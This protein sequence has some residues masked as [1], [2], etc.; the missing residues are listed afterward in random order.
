MGITLR[1][2]SSGPERSA[3]TTVV[4]GCITLFLVPFAGMG[5]LAAGSGLQRGMQ[6]NWREGLLLMLF[7][8]VFT[9]FAA[10]F[11]ALMVVGRNQVR[12]QERRRKAHPDQPWLW[13]TEWASGRIADATRSTLWA[14]WLFA[15]LWNLVSIP[16]GVVGVRAAWQQGN[17]AGYV[18]LLFPLVGLGLLFWAVRTTLRHRRYGT[19]WL[20]LATHPGVIGRSISGTVRVSSPIQSSDGFEVTLRCVRRIRTRSGKSSS[21]SERVLWQEERRVAGAASRDPQGYSTRI[22]VRFTIPPDA[23]PSDPV[24]SDDQIVWRLELTASV[25]GV[26]YASTFEVP[27][28]RTAESESA[29]P[30]AQ[31]AEDEPAQEPYRRP[32]NSRIVVTTNRRGT[33]ILFPALRNPGVAAG[34]VGFTLGWTAVVLALLKFNAPLLFP[35]VFGLFWI[36]LVFG[37]LQQLLSVSRVV[38]QPG[39]LAVAHGYLSGGRERTIPASEIADITLKIGMQAGSR[40]YYDVMVA[41]SNGKQVAAGRWVRDKREAEWLAATIKKELG[42]LSR[43]SQVPAGHDG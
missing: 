32:A 15:L 27:V 14:S 16:V 5:L 17:P 35:I 39:S 21:T 12:E 23:Q 20:E 37:T 7:G 13:R 18:A 25:P 3:S 10:G 28:F 22:P 40:P 8:M 36:L 6:G 42:L 43:R 33:E 34:F 31:S 38:A 24:H 9:G 30:E 2:E 26:D 29:G 19:S 41:R 11:M 4:M 1:T